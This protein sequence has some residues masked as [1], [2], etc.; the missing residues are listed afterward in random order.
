MAKDHND[1]HSPPPAGETELERA[2]NIIQKAGLRRT[3]PREALLAFLI[4]KH[5]PYSTEEI[6]QSIKKKDLDVV[7]VYRCLAKFEEIG[8]VRRCDFGDGVARYEFQADPKHHHH[9][10]ICVSCRKTESLEDCDVLKYENVVKQLGYS[11][12]RHSLEFFGV[13]R[14]CNRG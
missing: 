8:L 1:A 13:C 3:K 14:T 12:I 5:G 10:V 4:R 6:F 9:H 11:N 7:T 2:L